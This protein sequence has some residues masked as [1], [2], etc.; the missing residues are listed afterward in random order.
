MLV[1]SWK[2]TKLYLYCGNLMNFVLVIFM[3]IS[4][5]CSSMQHYESSVLLH[6]NSSIDSNNSS[7]NNVSLKDLPES[8]LNQ[9]LP[10]TG[11]FWNM[12][13]LKYRFLF[14]LVYSCFRMV[15]AVNTQI[16]GL[17][18]SWKVT[19]LCF[20]CVNLMNFVLVI[21]MTISVPCSSMQHYESSVLLRNNSSTESNNSSFNNV[22]LQDLPK[23]QLNQSS[24]VTEPFWNMKINSRQ[25]YCK[26][27]T[28]DFHPIP[29]TLPLYSKFKLIRNHIN[30][31][32]L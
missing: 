16:F 27:N 4:M 25:S 29:Q 13:I 24:Q 6:N 32:N 9:S 1:G 28:E 3:M 15:V 11:P 7:F 31:H 23:S 20:Y 21:F 19:K 26:Y 5:P 12:N 8:Q 10:V 17:V 30:N 2:V 18:G 14:N 22:S